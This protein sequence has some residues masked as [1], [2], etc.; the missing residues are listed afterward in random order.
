MPPVQLARLVQALEI[1]PGARLLVVAGATGYS[2]AILDRLGADVVLLEEEESL[3]AAARENLGGLGADRVRVVTGPLVRGHPAGA[4]Y[5]AI[6][7]DGAIEVLPDALAGQLAPAGHIATVYRDER[8][9][10]AMIFERVGDDVTKWP[11]FDAWLDVLP[12]FER[13]RE[14][15]F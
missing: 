14:F 10:R 12:G 15:V 11:L 8:L 3:A 13:A 4:P 5:D 6:L 7:I 9:S 2:A 1:A